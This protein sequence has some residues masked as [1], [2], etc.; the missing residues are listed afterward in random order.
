M[1]EEK[2]S[3]ARRFLDAYAVIERELGTMA[4]E[5]KYIPFSQLLYRCAQRSWV[6]SKNQQALREYHELRNAIVHLRG[7][8]N[9]IIAEPSDSVT[10]DIERI[11]GLLTVDES[12]LSCASRPVKTVCSS[13]GIRGAYTMMAGL[14]SS[15]IPVYDNGRF[16][17]ILTMENICRWA[18]DGMDESLHVGDIMKES[19]KERVIFLKKNASVI[20]AT[21]AFEQAM[22]HGS[23]LLAVI[24]TEHG[25]A[26]EKPL[27]IITVKDLPKIVSALV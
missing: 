8:E 21:R 11:A 27:G 19:R 26:N 1:S 23:V 9:E 3:N 2:F 15:K 13:D 22:N 24:V 18:F 25:S 10:E 6:V 17:G 4:R 12:I 16:R 5:T 14:D 7:N 20:E